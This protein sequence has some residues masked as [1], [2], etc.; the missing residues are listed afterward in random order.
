MTRRSS[1]LALVLIL[2]ATRPGAAQAPAA[3][4]ALADSARVAELVAHA[5]A[6]AGMQWSETVDFFCGRDTARANRADDPEL[7]PARVFDNLYALGRT[8]T[9]IWAIKTPA[10]IALIDAGYPDQV[11]SVL[12]PGLRK[13]GLDPND[14]KLVLLAHGHCGSLRR[15]GVFPAARCARRPVGRG[16]GPDAE[17][18]CDPAALRRAVDGRTSPPPAN[19]PSP[20]SA[21]ALPPPR[22]DLVVIDGQPLALGGVRSRRSRSPVTRRARS[23]SCSRSRTAAERTRRR[24]SAAR[25]CSRREYRTRARTVRAL[26]R[27]FR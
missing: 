4:P 10:G 17:P 2:A 22:R 21:T 3:A 18:A 5:R 8:S 23:A 19:A 14:V 26:R 24:C 12:L 20:S 25:S 27:A 11:E 15:R 6:A 9:V 7:A 1:G 16:L 13:L